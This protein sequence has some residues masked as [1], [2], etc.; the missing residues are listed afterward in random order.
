MNKISNYIKEELGKK[1]GLSMNDV[2]IESL[3]NELVIYRKNIESTAGETRLIISKDDRYSFEI[4]SSYSASLESGVS[5]SYEVVIDSFSKQDVI[6]IVKILSK[7]LD[8]SPV[9]IYKSL[10]KN[11]RP[12]NLGV[13]FINRPLVLINAL[14]KFSV[15]GFLARPNDLGAYKF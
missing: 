11:E 6:A 10:G 1:W 14:T 13:Y 15:K 9:L 8:I 12:V 3:V 4:P 7:Y 2:I 5:W